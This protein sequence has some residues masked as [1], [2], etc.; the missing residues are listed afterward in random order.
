MEMIAPAGSV[1]QA[2]TLSGNPLAVAAGL[3]TLKLLDD[4][5]YLQLEQTTRALA[6]GLSAAAREA[7]VPVKITWAPGLLTLF[8]TDGDVTDLH[9]VKACDFDAHA[10]F[11]RAMLAHGVYLPPSQYEAWFPS[12]AHGEEQLEATLEAAA[13]SFAEIAG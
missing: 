6:Q 1:Y 11:C 4:S 3:A 10:A 12:L 2:G 7:G 8:F 13:R 9:S 5:A